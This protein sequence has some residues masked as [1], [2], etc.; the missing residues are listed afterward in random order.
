MNQIGPISGSQ[1]PVI[2]QTA[3]AKAFVNYQEGGFNENYDKMGRHLTKAKG[4]K[5]NNMNLRCFRNV[6]SHDYHPMYKGISRKASRNNSKPVST[7]VSPMHDKDK[8]FMFSQSSRS[9]KNAE[10]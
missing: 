7:V 6:P 2:P 1:V 10:S 4:K 5:Y 9:P 3:K 8:T